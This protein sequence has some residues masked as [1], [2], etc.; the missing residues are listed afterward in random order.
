MFEFFIQRS[1]ETGLDNLSENFGIQIISFISTVLTEK[2]VG[3]SVL[4]E[5]MT[6]GIY[7][8]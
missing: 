5:E 8:R 2:L 3:C 6:S 1:D 4:Q 7:H